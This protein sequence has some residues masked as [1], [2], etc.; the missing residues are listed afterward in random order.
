MA[1]HEYATGA[2]WTDRAV[3]HLAGIWRLELGAFVAAFV[4]VGVILVIDCDLRNLGLGFSQ[5]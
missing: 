5:D 2:L 4:A 3:D 1:W